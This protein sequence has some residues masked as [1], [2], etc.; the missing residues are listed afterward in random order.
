MPDETDEESG[1]PP[2]GQLERVLALLELL[3]ANARGLQLVD[4]AERLRIPR[5]ATHRLLTSLCEHGYARQERHAGAYRMTA[6]I[7]S[8]G[9]TF[10]RGF[11]VTDLAQP[12]LD[13][14]A[15][16]SREL[17]RLALVDGRRLIWVAKAQGEPHGLRYDP[18]MGQEAR[19]SCSASGMAWLA[20]LPDAEALALVE[21]QGFG[22]REDYGPKAPETEQAF[23]KYLRAARKQGYAKTFHTY[24]DWM[25][26]IA[27]P[28][29]DPATKEVAGT[30][31]IAG[32]AFRLTEARMEE[33][34]PGLLK[35]AEELAPVLAALP[36][37]V[38]SLSR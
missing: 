24:S 35:A 38:P 11:G 29:F 4:I 22:R 16:E 23:L 18:E 32:P 25:S 26:T 34:A 21:K 12:I 37:L 7:A 9:F 33:L 2:S 8:L 30:V 10:L 36:G 13:R 20:C 27:A 1:Q 19:L 28:I 14:L 31:N 3:A 6:K 17:A 5:S 15:R